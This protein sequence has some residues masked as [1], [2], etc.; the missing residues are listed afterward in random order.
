MAGRQRTDGSV[1]AS[2]DDGQIGLEGVRHGQHDGGEGGHV[3]SV[4]HATRAPRDVHVVPH[5]LASPRLVGPA[6][7]RVK[8]ALREQNNICRARLL[9]RGCDVFIRTQ[10]PMDAL[11]GH[12]PG[13]RFIALTMSN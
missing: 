9:V 8:V 5:P 1:E 7:A 10:L 3:V 2:A 11:Q 4:R 12:Q 6:R 13:V